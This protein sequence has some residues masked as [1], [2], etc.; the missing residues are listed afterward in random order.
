MHGCAHKSALHKNGELTVKKETPIALTERQNRGCKKNERKNKQIARKQN[1]KQKQNTRRENCRIFR[2]NTAADPRPSIDR[3]AH[4]AHTHTAH[5]A[6]HYWR[7][8]WKPMW[9]RMGEKVHQHKKRKIPKT[10]F[11]VAQCTLQARSSAP[12]FQ[13][14]FCSLCT[15][16]AA[17]FFTILN[18]DFAFW[19]LVRLWVWIIIRENSHPPI[20]H[21]S[22]CCRSTIL[23]HLYLCMFGGLPCSV[24]TR[25]W[26]EKQKNVARRA[27]V[28]YAIFVFARFHLRTAYQFF[29]SV[30]VS[31]L[32]LRISLLLFETH[33]EWCFM[34][35]RTGHVGGG[36]RWCKWRMHTHDASR[37]IKFS[38]FQ[39]STNVHKKFVLHMR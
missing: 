14:F 23:H 5:I 34:Y 21:S 3:S 15:R 6:A 12:Y 4:L 7:R 31:F 39:L 1:S 2:P 38:A 8:V 22:C 27:S 33:F 37:F 10:H 29:F 24:Y 25:V 32:Y 18:L 13:P 9:G 36:M 30:C 20:S 17:S 28:R 26:R 11:P 16:E 19:V 35:A